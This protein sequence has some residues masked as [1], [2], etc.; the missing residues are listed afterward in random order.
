MVSTINSAFQIRTIFAQFFHPLVCLVGIA[1]TLV[2]FRNSIPVRLRHLDAVLLHKRIDKLVRALHHR[3]EAAERSPH[4]DVE[5]VANTRNEQ[6]LR[7]LWQIEER[8]RRF[9]LELRNHYRQTATVASLRSN[10]LGQPLKKLLQ[11]AALDAAAH[12][13]HRHITALLVNKPLRQ[14]GSRLI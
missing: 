9:V 10:A 11:D 14:I 3:D 4:V 1:L 6:I 2:A 13:H 7:R 8:F 5:A 12:Q